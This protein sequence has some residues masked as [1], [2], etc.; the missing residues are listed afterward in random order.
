MEEQG[1]DTVFANAW[2]EQRLWDIGET[3]NRA[4]W[5]SR[6]INHASGLA[7]LSYLSSCE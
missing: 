6:D 7:L 3:N 2:K 5:C 1:G 4:V